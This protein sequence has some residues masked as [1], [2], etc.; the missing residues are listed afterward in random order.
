MDKNHDN[1]LINK[2]CSNYTSSYKEHLEDLIK[3]KKNANKIFISA[4]IHRCE[5]VCH[6]LRDYHNL[7]K[8]EI[9]D[10][11]YVDLHIC[12]KWKL[13]K[14]L[15]QCFPEELKCNKNYIYIGIPLLKSKNDIKGHCCHCNNITNILLSC[16]HYLCMCCIK[17]VCRNVKIKKPKICPEC[18]IYI[19]CCY[20]SSTITSD[21]YHCIQ[22]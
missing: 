20:K 8:R 16:G 14:L 18:K 12:K 11:I 10:T 4:Y 19:D 7:V 6:W 3:N 22:N 13:L 9:I 1:I 21:S 17:V 2:Y 15:N 5:P